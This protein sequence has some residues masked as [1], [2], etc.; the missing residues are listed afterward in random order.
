MRVDL[1]LSRIC[2]CKHLFTA[3]LNFPWHNCWPY[4]HLLLIYQISFIIRT[5]ISRTNV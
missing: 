4:Y 1:T 2:L 5:N 3:V